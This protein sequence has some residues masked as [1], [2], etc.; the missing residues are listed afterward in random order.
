MPRYLVLI[1]RFSKFGRKI[2]EWISKFG[3][4]GTP[5]LTG[6][7][8]IQHPWSLYLYDDQSSTTEVDI[9]AEQKALSSKF[10]YLHARNGKLPDILSSR[11]RLCQF[12]IILWPLQMKFWNLFD[13]IFDI[14]TV[15]FVTF[16]IYLYN[17]FCWKVNSQL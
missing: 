17:N 7:P 9:V 14:Q 11:L 1:L 13:Y 16:I 15:K 10:F 5:F 6:D 4:K 3:R 12:G 8:S 2:K